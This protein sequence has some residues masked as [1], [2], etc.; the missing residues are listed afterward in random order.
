M[1]D[2]FDIICKNVASL[3]KHIFKAYDIRGIVPSD[4]NED[5]VFNIGC[6]VFGTKAK[7]LADSQV[8]IARDSRLSGP[9]L[10]QALESS[11]LVSGCDVLNV[12]A[13]PTPVLYFAANQH[14]WYV[15]YAY[16]QS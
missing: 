11:I 10:F 12:G 14:K 9:S 1:F 16:R 7:K 15:D 6:V 5:I 2:L 4:L 13:V 8:A 3:L